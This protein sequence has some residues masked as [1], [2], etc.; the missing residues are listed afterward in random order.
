M[1]VGRNERQSG[2]EEETDTDWKAEAKNLNEN[3]LK[4][5]FSGSV[6]FPEQ[7]LSS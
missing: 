5:E 6:R 3:V 7:D 1:L 2:R 4:D